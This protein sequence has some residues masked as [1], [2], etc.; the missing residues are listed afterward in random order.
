MSGTGVHFYPWNNFSVIPIHQGQFPGY[1]QTDQGINISFVK[2][3]M[4]AFF[5]PGLTDKII[6]IFFLNP[7]MLLGKKAHAV[8]MIP[9][10]MRYYDISNFIRFNIQLL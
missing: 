10:R 4:S 7:D 3:A 1:I 8:N 5:L 9:M 6:I 2:S